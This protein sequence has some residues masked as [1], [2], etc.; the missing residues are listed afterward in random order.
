M[1]SQNGSIDG[2]DLASVVAGPSRPDPEVPERLERARRRQFTVG[3]KLRILS[4]AD[5]ART[6]GEIGALLR[7]EGLYSSHLAAWRRQREEG[8]LN[9]LSPRRRGRPTSSPEQQRNF[10][11][12]LDHGFGCHKPLAQPL[13]L[14][15]QPR[16]LPLLGRAR[17][18]TTPPG[19]Q[20]VEDPFLALPTPRRQV[21]RIQPFPTQ[22][23]TDLARRPGRIGLA[24]DPQLVPHREL[25]PTRTLQPLG[26]FGVRSTH[27]ARR[28]SHFLPVDGAVLRR[29]GLSSFSTLTH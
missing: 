29:H 18:P 7:R 26:Y 3:Y 28:S 20:R 9:A 6:T 14:L 22:Q 10:F 11:L 4:E 23:G 5:V 24:Q 25:P 1:T 15:P 2:K 17:W 27:L 12:D 13:V 21:R 8:I 19:T 16:Q